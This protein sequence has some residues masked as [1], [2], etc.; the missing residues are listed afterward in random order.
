VGPAPLP[1]DLQQHLHR[2][3]ETLLTAHVAVLQVKI[4]NLKYSSNK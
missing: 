2:L 4:K 3:R 1:A